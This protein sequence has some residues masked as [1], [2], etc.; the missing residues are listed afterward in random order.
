MSISAR[1]AQ[2]E[3]SRIVG[4]R[5]Q[6][7]VLL[8]APDKTSRQDIGRGRYDLPAGSRGAVTQYNS[9]AANSFPPLP[10]GSIYA[11][12][13]FLESPDALHPA[14]QK[15][16]MIERALLFVSTAAAL[17]FAAFLLFTPL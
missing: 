8:R 6:T 9:G 7:Q 12:G 16:R 13:A 15:F 14:L 1:I 10:S 3:S 2:M 4:G 5:A 11:S 17:V